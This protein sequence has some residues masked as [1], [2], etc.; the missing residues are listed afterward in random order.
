M[1]TAALFSLV[2]TALAATAPA[3]RAQEATVPE[4]AMTF[5]AMADIVKALDPDAT[6][7]AGGIGLTIG[8][9]PV[10][11]VADAQANRM[12]ILVPIASV[13]GLSEADLLR[14]MQANFDTALDAR[15]AV[16]NERLWSVYIHPLAELERSQFVSGLAQTVTLARNYG[17][18]YSSGGA[19]FGGGDSGA[20]YRELLDRSEEL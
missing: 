13:A 17:G 18:T 19:I 8:N 11:I 12:R 6:V 2:L 1:K 5:S 4:P 7:S 20:L 15:Y 9:V 16:A 3:T 10:T 14:L